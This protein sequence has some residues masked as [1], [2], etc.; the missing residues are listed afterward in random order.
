M[1]PQ[2]NQE[3]TAKV[4]DQANNRSKN[5]A[6]LVQ[7]KFVNEDYH[8]PKRR[9]MRKKIVNKNSTGRKNTNGS[10]D[11]KEVS[12]SV[13]LISMQKLKLPFAS[14]IDQKM[15]QKDRLLGVINRNMDKEIV[16]V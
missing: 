6:N 11:V 5:G 13:D 3:T 7:N 10:E 9:I 14:F 15:I 4:A 16:T 12:S 2:L 8:L 1:L